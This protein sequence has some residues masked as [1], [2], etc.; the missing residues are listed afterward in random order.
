MLSN[1]F[2]I[3]E[4]EYNEHFEF[5]EAEKESHRG[6]SKNKMNDYFLREFQ[7]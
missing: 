4:E 5:R 7:A 3:K 1:I 2:I 6:D